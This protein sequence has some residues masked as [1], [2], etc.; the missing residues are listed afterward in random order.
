MKKEWMEP[1]VEVQEFAA[2]EYVKKRPAGIG[3]GKFINL[4]AMLDN[5]VIII[6]FIIMMD[7]GKKN[8]SQKK[9][10]G[11]AGALKLN[12]LDIILVTRLMKRNL[13][14]DLSV[15]L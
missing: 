14:V 6:M 15:V 12:F 3:T 4:S 10:H 9:T 13:T 11:E 2:N 8:I 1:V 5:T 7:L